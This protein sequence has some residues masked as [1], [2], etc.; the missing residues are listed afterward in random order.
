MGLPG[1]KP[2]GGCFHHGGNAKEAKAI[3]GLLV[4]NK[5]IN[6]TMIPSIYR[7]DFNADP[8]VYPTT[9]LQFYYNSPPVGCAMIFSP[10]S[11]LQKLPFGYVYFSSASSVYPMLYPGESGVT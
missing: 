1:L 3:V 4:N 9:E 5:N 8:A 11:L 7:H 10:I 2:R 6:I